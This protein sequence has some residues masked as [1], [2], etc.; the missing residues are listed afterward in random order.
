[1]AGTITASGSGSGIDIEL[2]VEKLT[3]VEREPIENRL[4]LREVQI[5]ADVSAF[6]TLKGAITD[7]KASLSGLSSIPNFSVRSA[8]SSNEDIFTVSASSDAV[9]GSTTIEV[10][11]LATAQK[12]VSNDFALPNSAVGQGDLTITVGSNAFNLSI[13]SNNNTL[14]GI[15]DAI[16][17]AT[18]NTGVTASI[19]TVDDANSP[20]NTVSKIVLS[21]DSTGVDNALTVSVANDADGNDTDGI[22]LSQLVYVSGVTQNLTELSNA[23]DAIIEVDGF[24]VSSST[25]TFTG[26][27]P[28]VTINAVSADLGNTYDMNIALDKSAVKTK[29]TDLVAALNA[30]KTTYDFLTEVDLES[31]ESGLLTGDATAR[32]INNQVTRLVSATVSSGTGNY[33]SLA[34]I[35]ITLSQDGEYELDEDM[36]DTALN[37][38]FDAVSELIAGDSGIASQLD[39]KLESF[40]QSGGIISSINDTLESQLT[41]ISEQRTA[42][43]LR[44]ESVEERLRKQ[45]TAMDIIVAQF[46]STGDF[47]TQQLESIQPKK[48]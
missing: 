42:L 27:I 15:R 19:L 45:F 25:N 11:Q 21:S 10:E 36:L 2:L 16:N 3:A 33:S 5:Q 39:D 40:L 30:Y 17:D 4:N 48:D 14:T 32:T 22:G 8:T 38:D 7:L 35:G 46:N 20:G 18:T 41:D 12:L 37:S 13:D 23:Q 44:I 34:T 24:D 43:D 29:V 47:L 1:M 9:P 26:V 6:G 28:G 31:K